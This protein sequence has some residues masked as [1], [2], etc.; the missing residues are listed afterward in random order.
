MNSEI[1]K[2]ASNSE[3]ILSAKNNKTCSKKLY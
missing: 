1:G 3:H 2:I